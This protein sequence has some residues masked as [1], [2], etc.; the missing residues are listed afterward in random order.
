MIQS[1]HLAGARN[2]NSELD[3]Y[4]TPS[5]ATVAL[6]KRIKFDGTVWECANGLGAISKIIS[7]YNPIEVSDITDGTDFLLSSH[8]VD[9]IVTNPPYKWAENF[10]IQADRLTLKKYAMFLRLNF[11]ESQSR[12]QLFKKL[13]LEYVLVFSKR[14]TLHPINSTVITGGT[15]AYAWFIWNK[16][17]HGKPVLDWIND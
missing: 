9:N 14:Q 3:L 6:M 17:Y 11:L 2:N 4:E 12:Y 10:V 15:I 7:K 16:E 8:I 13:P 5:Y 1:S